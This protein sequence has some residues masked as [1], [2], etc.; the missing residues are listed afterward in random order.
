MS[1]EIGEAL[2]RARVERDMELDEI[3][4]ITKIRQRYLHALEDG[5]WEQLP[6]LAYARTF[7]RSYADAV[8]LDA[9]EL[10]ASLERELGDERRAPA[11]PPARHPAPPG[12]APVESASERGAALAGAETIRGG[13]GRRFGLS[14]RLVA[15][16]A[17]AAVAGVVAVLALSSGGAEEVPTP[18]T[19][20]R[21][22]P[23]PEP[24]GAPPEP[25]A[26]ERR[27]SDAPQRKLSLTITPQRE[28]WVCLVDAR[29]REVVAGAILPAGIS[30]GPFR[31]RAF[32]LA[33]GHGFID[34]EINGKPAKVPGA[35]NPMGFLLE[36]DGVQRV[37]VED[38][39][40]CV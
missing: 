34:L 25:Q 27:S 9:T 32:T 24:Q 2:R 39:S 17:A 4:R 30:E 12:A 33:V 31:S 5:R 8:G 11:A 36:S 16:V 19:T 10:V 35:A 13:A 20:D 37:P 38:V 26:A 7:L 1:T 18:Q 22:V 3:E 23:A 29:A 15:G 21:D 14:P 28:A 40:D 6:D